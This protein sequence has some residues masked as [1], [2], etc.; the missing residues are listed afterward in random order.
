MVMQSL[1]ANAAPY[2]QGAVCVRSKTSENVEMCGAKC[3]ICGWEDFCL[4]R[5]SN[6]QLHRTSSGTNELSSCRSVIGISV[7][8]DK[9][10]FKSN[11]TEIT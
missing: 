4:P 9:G 2:N 11:S 8:Y 5:G 10:H 3:K 7:S 6:P 1:P